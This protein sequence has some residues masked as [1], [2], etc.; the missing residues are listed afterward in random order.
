[1]QRI[2]SVQL[3]QL[4]GGCRL[5]HGACLAWYSMTLEDGTE[6]FNPCWQ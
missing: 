3:H 5:G 2:K 1:M 4:A 6:V